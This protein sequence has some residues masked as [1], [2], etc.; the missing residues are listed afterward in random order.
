MKRRAVIEHAVGEDRAAIY[1]GRRLVELHVDRPWQKTPRT[2]D[3]YVGRVTSI[4]QSVAGAWV[5]LGADADSALLPFAAQK[6]MP[7]LTEGKSV[8]VSVLRSQIGTKGATLR[9]K[10]ESNDKVGLV[11]KLDLKSRL[12]QRYPDLSFDEA[13]VNAVDA[14]CEETSLA[15]P[16]GGSITLEQTQ[17]LLAIDVDKGSAVSAAAAANEAAKLIASQ[18]RL[19][20]LGGL[21]V[22]DFPNL[23]QP[24]Q[25]KALERTFEAAFEADPNITKFNSLSRFGVIE[26][27]RA[28]PD[29]SLD[30]I[31]NTKY[32]SSSIETQSLR[33][34]RRLTREAAISS[35]AQLELIITPE[36]N[37][38]LA[39]APFDWRLDV[40]NRIGARYKLVIG[41]M[42]D[43]KADR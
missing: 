7:K 21:V 9:F 19:R 15:L 5:D 25:R 3:Q 22:V 14:A 23:R 11:K 26:M 41:A 39:S 43:V 38:W 20:G 28:K 18:L 37:D 42:V 13:A 34:L 4:D 17:A 35:G 10:A 29:L 8:E 31:L 36:I 12:L 27:T 32:A 2:G 33:A 1:E 40:T 30:D 6:N 16:S 24:K